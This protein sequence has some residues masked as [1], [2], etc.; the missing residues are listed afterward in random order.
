MDSIELRSEKVR[1]I[2]GKMPPFLIRSGISIIIFVFIGIIGGSYFFKYPVSISSKASLN[3]KTKTATLHI[4]EKEID[5]I[6]VGQS[7]QLTFTQ[8]EEPEILLAAKIEK[9]SDSLFIENDGAYK[10]VQASYTIDSKLS[11]QA[12]AQ[13][14]VKIKIGEKRAIEKIVSFVTRE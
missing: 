3:P 13:A 14:M 5:K 7:I 11:I 9:I 10:K 6:K 1:N 2:I 4:L 12:N 8:I